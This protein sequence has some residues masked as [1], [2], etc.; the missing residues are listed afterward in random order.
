M[1]V[2]IYISFRIQDKMKLYF[3]TNLFHFFKV[4][5]WI[6]NKNGFF[7]SIKPR[8]YIPYT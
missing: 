7:L 4:F 8:G 1:Y 5:K 6:S 3:R 2:C